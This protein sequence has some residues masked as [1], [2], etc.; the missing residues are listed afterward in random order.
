LASTIQRPLEPQA[1]FRAA[2]DEPLHGL[3]R[4]DGA[5]V[6]AN[7]A[8]VLALSRLPGLDDPRGA[9]ET[10]RALRAIARLLDAARAPV[11]VGRQFVDNVTAALLAHRSRGRARPWDGEATVEMF[12]ELYGRVLGFDDHGFAR[13]RATLMEAARG[14]AA[15][16]RS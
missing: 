9:A 12:M 10:A 4:L 1:A 13:V 2:L 7:E 5:P 16:R 14:P 3:A 6:G 11:A 8:L 15:R